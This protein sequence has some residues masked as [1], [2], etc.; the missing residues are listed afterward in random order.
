MVALLGAAGLRIAAC[1]AGC[2]AATLAQRPVLAGRLLLLDSCLACANP[3]GPLAWVTPR[4]SNAILRATPVHLHD[5]RCP[6][7]S[8]DAFEGLDFWQ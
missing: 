1:A 8:S 7:G 4:T 6:C 5:V 2:D 3:D